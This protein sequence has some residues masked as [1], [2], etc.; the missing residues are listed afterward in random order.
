MNKCKICNSEADKTGSHIIPHFLLKRIDSEQGKPER[1]REM[2]FVINERNPYSYFGR[3]TSSTKLEEIYGKVSDERISE[4][5]IPL[6]EDYIFCKRCEEEFGLLESNYSKSIYQNISEENI[7]IYTGIKNEIALLFWISILFRLSVAKNSGFNLAEKHH[8]ILR[9]IL[10]DYFSNKKTPDKLEKVKYKIARA[11]NFSNDNPTVLNIHTSKSNPYQ[12][13]LDEFI[14]F[15]SIDNEDEI[16]NDDV[17][18]V[19]FNINELPENYLNSNEEESIYLISHDLMLNISKAFFNIAAEKYLDNL[20]N[21]C[22]QIYQ[23]LKLG[24]SMPLNVKEEII[25]GICYD[26]EVSFGD[27]YTLKHKSTVISK[28][29]TKFFST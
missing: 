26:P 11:V 2:G 20:K 25:F 12:L 10:N 14:L 6:I 21:E 15:M 8:E 5:S 9:E 28:V 29:L 24:D 3:A 23:A 22:D 16:K 13:I 17:Y 7:L 4:N 19:E 1:D 18:E 27:R